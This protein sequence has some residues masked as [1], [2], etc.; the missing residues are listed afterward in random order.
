MTDLSTMA[1][2]FFER[3]GYPDW[4]RQHSRVVGAVGAVLARAR[5]DAGDRID[6]DAVTLAAY[7]HDIGR[8]PLLA[9]DPR[10]HNELSALV[11]AAEGLDAC[12]EPARR[13]AI[14]TVLDPATAPRGLDEKVVYVA[15]RRGGMAVES[16]EERARDTARR[17]PRY[18]DE[19]A[20]AIPIAKTIER[21]VFAGLPFGPDELASR[22]RV[23]AAP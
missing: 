15:D 4:L 1:E 10:E 9:G 22:V 21:E 17:H 18:T 2:R 11:L 8:S 23:E 6:A 7:L 16:L 12:V 3:Y 20:R 13:H 19:I 5:A 14:Y